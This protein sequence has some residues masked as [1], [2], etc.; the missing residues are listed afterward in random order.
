MDWKL[1]D[2]RMFIENI[3]KLLQ[4]VEIE[5]FWFQTVYDHGLKTV[6]FGS[7]YNDGCVDMAFAKS[8]ALIGICNCQIINFLIYQFVD[9]FCVAQTI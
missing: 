4:V 6:C 2:L 5:D 3:D 7:E 8:Y 9:N 1:L